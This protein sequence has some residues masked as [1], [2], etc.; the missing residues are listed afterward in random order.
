MTSVA[1]DDLVVAAPERFWTKARKVGLGLAIA[2]TL[3]AVGFG[4]LATGEDAIFTLTEDPTGAHISIDGMLGAI[5]FGVIGALAGL[6]LLAPAMDRYFVW[7]LGVGIVAVVLSFLCWQVSSAPPGLNFMPLVDIVRGTFIFALPLIFGSLA[8]ALCERSGVVNVAIE[9]Q[10]LAGA[11]GGA[12]V[13]TIAGSAWVGLL[14]GI[15]G[16]VAISAMLAW[17]SIKYLVDQV[18]LGVVLNLFA[19]GLTGFIYE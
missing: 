8:G 18:V 16:G 2:G 11:F 7:L 19:I 1:F 9:G 4:A 6:A 12:L 10:L 15:L 17:F 14:G 3:A 5:V 13:G